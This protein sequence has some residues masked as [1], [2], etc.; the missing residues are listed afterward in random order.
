MVPVLTCPRPAG[1]Q[2]EPP[3]SGKTLPA[4]WRELGAACLLLP[5]LSCARVRAGSAG[6]RLALASAPLAVFRFLGEARCLE[7]ELA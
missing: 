4:D 5:E 2:E 3:A 1:G 7:E 6:Q